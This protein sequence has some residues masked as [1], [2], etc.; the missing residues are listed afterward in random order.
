MRAS[1]I[2]PIKSNYSSYTIFPGIGAGGLPNLVFLSATFRYV[3]GS[4]L[5][6]PTLLVPLLIEALE[7]WFG[8]HGRFPPILC[9]WWVYKTAEKNSERSELARVPHTKK[10]RDVP[11]CGALGL[12]QKPLRLRRRY[13]A[14]APMPVPAAALAVRRRYLMGCP[15]RGPRRRAST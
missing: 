6:P 11:R 4:V 9:V 13:S 3:K 2:S 12:L 1:S 7:Y 5:F 15:G 10:P 8:F 14:V